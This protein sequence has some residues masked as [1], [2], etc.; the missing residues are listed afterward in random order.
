MEFW[1]EKAQVPCSFNGLL[2]ERF[3]LDKVRLKFEDPFIAACI[4]FALLLALPSQICSVKATFGED[5]FDTFCLVWIL[6]VIWREYHWLNNS[7][8]ISNIPAFS[9]T[10][11][12]PTR[13]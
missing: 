1:Q 10:C 11:L 8:A 7:L 4:G 3:L 13:S 6:G 2:N 12:L 9:H 5:S